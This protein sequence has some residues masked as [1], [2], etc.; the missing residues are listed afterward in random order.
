M[1][2]DRL[3]VTNGRPSS[4]PRLYASEAARAT[5]SAAAVALAAMWLYRRSLGFA[6]F[7]DDPTGHFAW[8][9]GRSLLQFFTSSAEY[10]YY[11]PV[12][13]AV[14]RL[15]ETLFGNDV[16]P[17]NPVADHAL[18]WLLHGANAVLVWLLARRLSGRAGLAWVAALVFAAV[19]F[20]YEA[21]A[22]VASLTH[23]LLVFWLLAT[24]LLY[25]L[26]QS[27]HV[28][29]VAVEQGMERRRCYRPAAV[30]T[31]ILGLLTHENG[32]VI[33]PALV[34]LDWVARPR[35]TVSERA[36][37]L[38]P[39]VVPPLLFVA[40]WLS[41][42]KNSQQGLNSP[43]DIA[44]NII[45]FLQTLVYPLLPALRLDAGDVVGLTLAAT[46]VVAVMGLFAW[47]AGA[48][49]LWV[50]ALGWFGLSALPAL[51][52]LGPAYVYGSP[53]LS[54]LP[55]IGVGM[56]WAIPVLWLGGRPMAGKYTVSAPARSLLCAIYL[57]ALTFPALPFIRCQLDFYDEASRFARGM[58]DS[59]TD[60]PAG[61][62]VVFVNAPFFFSSTADRPE[63]CPSPYPWTP[64]G[65]VLIPP[66]ARARDFVRFNGGPDRDVAAVS[67]AGYA[68]GWR[69]SGPEIDGQTL[70]AHAAG[71]VVYV[72]DLLKG[73]FADLSAA[74]QP[75]SAGQAAPMAG[76]GGLLALLDART[77]L[78]E[79]R[80]EI[81]LDWR[82]EATAEMP[83]V[84]FVHVYDAA[85]GLAAQSDAPPGDGL[86]PQD[87]WRPGDGLRDRSQIDLSSLP[88]GS[89]R[90]VVGVYQATDGV[91]LAVKANGQTLGDNVFPIHTFERP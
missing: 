60:A 74:W 26:S 32:L 90:V 70:R 61:Q 2:S 73:S 57:A 18:L 41:I 45:P 22:Y 82:V 50:Y 21:V 79:D 25:D 13:F 3:G 29:T 85:G 83:L 53:R 55:S 33:F 17:H 78:E 58:A 62:Q 87:Q 35:S 63:G 7:N 72:F 42:P 9:E 10:G 16:F 86:A 34:G 37:A 81:T 47:R 49:R 23:P 11:R 39:F 31:L 84:A 52:F 46:A 19:P 77:T 66:Y 89:Y 91:R 15:T 38:W 30:A 76:F 48:T 44:G 14:L 1:Q 56:L 68:P 67:Y 75:G 59:A 8:M 6:Y 80:L 12:V 54:Y 43:T 51:L 65:A 28:T 69:T 27:A 64:V 40:L 5:V 4:L 88:S 36:R 71:D 24:L 20:S